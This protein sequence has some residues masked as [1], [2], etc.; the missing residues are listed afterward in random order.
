MTEDRIFVDF[1]GLMS[2]G[3][4]LSD[5]YRRSAVY[6]DKIL[7]GAKPASLPV[8][9]PNKFELVINH[10]IA[11]RIGVAFHAVSREK[12]IANQRRSSV[13]SLRPPIHFK[14]H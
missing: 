5:L 9:E 8:E 1:D 11:K 4:N 14:L 7:K 12:Q 3:V 2:Y 13:E 10:K 6:V